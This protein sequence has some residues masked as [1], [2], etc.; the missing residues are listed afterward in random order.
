MSVSLALFICC[1]SISCSLCLYLSWYVSQAVSHCLCSVSTSACLSPDFVLHC[2]IVDWQNILFT[3]GNNNAF[4]LV[5]LEFML[6][7]V[8]SLLVRIYVCMTV[9][10]AQDTSMPYYAIY[11]MQLWLQVAKVYD[12][13]HLLCR[14]WSC[15]K[16]TCQFYHLYIWIMTQIHADTVPIALELKTYQVSESTELIEVCVTTTRILVIELS[17]VL[18]T[19]DMT[20]T[21][22]L[23]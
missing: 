20:A 5:V 11:L 23:V 7:K 17:V 22:K 13:T 6:G 18:S 2:F 8:T 9:R 21:G 19:R 14:L 12:F 15:N 16:L 10:K 4:L 1:V 3:W